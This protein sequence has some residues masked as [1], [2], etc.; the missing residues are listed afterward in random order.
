[1]TLIL[2]TALYR[3][4]PA[5]LRLTASKTTQLTGLKGFDPV[6]PQEEDL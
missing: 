1:M 2:P 4:L 6:N 5:A 3:P